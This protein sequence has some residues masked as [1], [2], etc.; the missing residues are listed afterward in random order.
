[1]ANEESNPE[2]E[3]TGK[4]SCLKEGKHFSRFVDFEQF[5]EDGDPAESVREWLRLGNNE[6]KCQD[7]ESKRRLMTIVKANDKTRA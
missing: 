1:M 2:V 7:L 5:D 3:R 6:R 4:T